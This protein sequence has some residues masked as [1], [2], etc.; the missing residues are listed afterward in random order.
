MKRAIKALSI[1]IILFAFVGQSNIA[2]TDKKLN[3]DTIGN[4]QRINE[5][6]TENADVYLTGQ[7]Q[8]TCIVDLEKVHFRD[9][10][11]TWQD[12]DNQIIEKTDE[13]G[14]IYYKNKANDIN[15][16]FKVNEMGYPVTEIRKDQ[17][18]I[19]CTMITDKCTLN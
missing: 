16:N 7:N 10:N 6:T 1:V 14:N 15:I 8:I 17:Y 3:S 18:S 11:G 9:M 4:Y 2:D 5:L 12:V 13:D 19:V